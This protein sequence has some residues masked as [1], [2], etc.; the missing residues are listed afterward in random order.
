MRRQ[1]AFSSAV[2]LL[3]LASV[4][5]PTA[6]GHIIVIGGAR[7]IGDDAIRALA[8]YRI[9]TVTRFCVLIGGLS[10]TA[11]GD[12][13]G[14]FESQGFDRVQPTG[15]P[16]GVEAEEQ[17]DGRGKRD[18]HTGHPVRNHRL[19][20][21]V[22]SDDLSDPRTTHKAAESADD[23]KEHCLGQKLA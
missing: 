17:S 4:P 18:G 15:A 22:P 8:E 14:L 6:Q 1:G 23:A 9:G 7:H 13:A 5:V 10:F 11:Q 20:T 19:P 21:E 12:A 2:I 3:V 16:G